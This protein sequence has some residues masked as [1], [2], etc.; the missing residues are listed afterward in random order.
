MQFVKSDDLKIGM[1]LARPIYNR[2]G[3]LLYERNSK[4]T[5]QGIM[6]IKAFGLIG[7]F[8]LEPAEPLP[9]MTEDDIEFE[10]FQMMQVFGIEEEMKR[11]W[12]N[13]KAGKIETIVSNIIKS[14]GHLDHKINFIQGLRSRED[15]LFKHSLNVAMLCAMFSHALRLKAEYQHSVVRAAVLHDIGQLKLPRELIGKNDLDEDEKKILDAKESEGFRI[16]DQVY[17]DDPSVKRIC[18]QC[19]HVVREF[20][21]GRRVEGR[22]TPEAM[23]M[24]VAQTFDQM[25]AMQFGQSPASEVKALKHLLNHPE[26]YDEDVVAAL[27]DSIH[28]LAPGTSVELNNKEKALVISLN[29]EDILRPM[30]LNFKDNSIIDLSLRG[31][32]Q[33]EIT[34]IMKTMDN[35]HV[36]DTALLKQHGFQVEEPNYVEVPAEA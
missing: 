14:Y 13:R 29:P 8:I 19:Y 5:G 4:L 6:S 25:T 10:R 9:P 15:Y 31:N 26:I 32:R 18:A 1:R 7:I 21:E 36:M 35:R 17:A 12:Q 22:L 24:I 20:Q 16:L 2:N 34:D 11:M 33:L 28:I 30:L 23:I 3:V 27:I